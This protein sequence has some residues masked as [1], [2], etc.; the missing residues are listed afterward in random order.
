MKMDDNDIKII[1]NLK[2][3]KKNVLSFNLDMLELRWKAVA[4]YRGVFY[5]PTTINVQL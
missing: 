1:I 4:I 5:M 2:D 3:A